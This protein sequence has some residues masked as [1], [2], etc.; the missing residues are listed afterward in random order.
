MYLVKKPLSLPKRKKK[1]QVFYG[2][3]VF[4]LKENFC[5]GNNSKWIKKV[6]F[7]I[8]IDLYF[9]GKMSRQ[10]Y[11]LRHT[12]FA[13]WIPWDGLF[14]LY[15]FLAWFFPSCSRSFINLSLWLWR[16]SQYL[17]HLSQLAIGF[18]TETPQSCRWSMKQAVRRRGLYFVLSL[19][20][21]TTQSI[22][23]LFL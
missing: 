13:K 1:M 6:F 3:R 12:A 8:Q 20:L 17:H 21:R 19:F 4:K 5:K 2:G 16:L 10:K 11:F 7:C 22:T 14:G 9:H 23:S 15:F 18:Q